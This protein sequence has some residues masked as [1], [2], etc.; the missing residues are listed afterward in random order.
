MTTTQREKKDTIKTVFIESLLVLI[1]GYKGPEFPF[2]CDGK[3]GG[4]GRLKGGKGR[5]EGE[6]REEFRKQDSVRR[7]SPYV[8]S[9]LFYL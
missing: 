2:P 3:Y 4:N 6:G 9:T 7:T 5:K 8:T 1:G